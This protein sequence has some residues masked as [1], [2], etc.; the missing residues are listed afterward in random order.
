MMVVPHNLMAMNANRQFNVVGRKKV[1][2]NEKLSSGYRINRAADDAAG[3]S[4]SEKMRNQI[5]GLQQGVKNTEDGVGLCQV[6]DGALHEVDNIIHRMK[7]LSVYAAN[8]VLSDEDREAIENEYCMLKSEINRIGEETEFNGRPLFRGKDIEVG[9]DG[10]TFGDVRFE[11]VELGMANVNLIEG[12]F[13]AGS[14]ADMLRFGVRT[15]ADTDVSGVDWNL[16]YGNGCT[17]SP[18]IKVYTEDTQGNISPAVPVRLRDMTVSNYQYDNATKAFS[19]TLSY[20]GSGVSFQINQKVKVN[21]KVGNEQYY[22]LSYEIKNTSSKKMNY[23]F[24]YHCDT[25]Y[26]NDDRCEGYYINGTRVNAATLYTTDSYY[27]NMGNTNIINGVP[28]SF[29]VCD[30]DNALQF[31]EKVIVDT[32]DKPD[33]LS[34]GHYAKIDDWGYYS[35]IGSH[36]GENMIRNDLG[37]SMIWSNRSLDTGASRT[38]SLKQ[39]VAETQNDSNVS[40][41][42]K[43]YNNARLVRHEYEDTLFIQSG[44]SAGEGMW[45]AIGQMDCEVLGLR[46]SSC[47]DQDSAGMAIEEVE[48][49]IKRINAIRSNIG[50]QQNRLEYTILNELNYSENL[51]SAE[52]NIRDIDVSEEMVEYSKHNILEQVGQSVLAQANQEQQNI[53]RLLQ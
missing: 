23:D 27:L 30:L 3:L 39:G 34:I 25:A 32:V 8:G 46:D 51:Q 10:V 14:S 16:I 35:N 44:C 38:H 5:R 22:S 18:V 50:A 36:L 48:V 31:T 20:N 9:A 12:P 42:T 26:N 45:L 41:I 11:Q 49:A 40:A 4:I 33:G 29:S 37:F 19:R 1:K 21:D 47:I 53:L 2:S 43:T 17:S 15:K 52:S 7:E 13:Q 6:A 24:M 28:D